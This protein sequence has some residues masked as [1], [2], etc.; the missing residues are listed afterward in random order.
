MTIN[1]YI[2][3]KNIKINSSSVIFKTDDD[4]DDNDDDDDGKLF[5]WYG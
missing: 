1:K 4:D 3:Y 2:N 5:L